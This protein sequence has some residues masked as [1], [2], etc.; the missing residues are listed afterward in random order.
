MVVD[1]DYSDVIAF[2]DILVEGSLPRKFQFLSVHKCPLKAYLKKSFITDKLRKD[3]YGFTRTREYLLE[4]RKFML[5]R[6]FQYSSRDL[7]W[8]DY[9]KSVGGPENL[10]AAGIFK[11]DRTLKIMVRRGIPAAFRSSIWQKISLSSMHR[12]GFP[13]N[14]FLSLVEKSQMGDLAHSVKLEIEK[15]L[16]RYRILYIGFDLIM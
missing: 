5:S 6:C 15:D 1:E 8:I 11:S 3:L 14:Y 7:D 13:S 2:I 9:L 4:E 12:L 16:D 10:K